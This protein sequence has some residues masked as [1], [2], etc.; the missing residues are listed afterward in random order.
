MDQ[1][2]IDAREARRRGLSYGQYIG[3]CKQSKPAAVR[4][5]KAA[6]PDQDGQRLCVICGSPIPKGTHRTK[7]CGPVCADKATQSQRKD[8]VRRR[9]EKHL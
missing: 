6:T 8:S 1:L 4:Y 9:L 3:L 2:D 7:Y 5:P